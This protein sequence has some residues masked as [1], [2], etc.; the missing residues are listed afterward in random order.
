[1]TGY[2][3]KVSWLRVSS[4]KK[5]TDNCTQVGGLNWRWPG[6][7]LVSWIEYWALIGW[8]EVSWAVNQSLTIIVTSI[9]ASCCPHTWYIDTFPLNY[10]PSATVPSIVSIL[11]TNKIQEGA[12][13]LLSHYYW[14]KVFFSKLKEQAYI[15]LFY[16]HF[17]VIIQKVY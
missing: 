6:L 1:M 12:S 13:R 2:E 11:P 16:D 4:F 15:Y 9:L 5:S 3:W 10:H 8:F 14:S 7:W 17:I